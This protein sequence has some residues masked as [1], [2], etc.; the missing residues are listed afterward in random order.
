MSE[1]FRKT[2]GADGRFTFAPETDGQAIATAPGFGLGHLSKDQ[3]I[4]LTVGDQP[5]NGRLVDLEGRPVAG[6]KVTLDQLW[7]PAAEPPGEPATLKNHGRTCAEN[8]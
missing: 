4:R 7:L 3:Q 2:T 1:S 6:V 5:I 8:A